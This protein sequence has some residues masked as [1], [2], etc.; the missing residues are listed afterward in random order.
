MNH[1][2]IDLRS[3]TVTR[4]S[5]G[6]RDAMMRADV[7]DDVYGEDPTVNFLQE[8]VSE[9]L[10]KDDALY[11]PSGTMSNQIAIKI[12]TQPG[13]EVICEENCHIFN[14]EAGASAFLSRVQMHTLRGNYGVLNIDDVKN[15]IR[16]ENVH[17]PPTGL[18]CIENTHNRAGGTIYPL[19]NIAEIAKLAAQ[20]GIPLHLDGARLMN[21]VVATGIP[22]REWTGYFDSVSLCFSKGLGAPIGSVLSGTKEFIHKARKYRKIFGGGMRQVG[23][24]AAACLYAL[25]NNIKRL[26]DD[27]ENACLLAENLKNLPGLFIDMKQVQTNMVM[28]HVRHSKFNSVTLSQALLQQGV[29]ANAVDAERIRAVTHLDITKDQILSAVEIF[30]D[31]IKDA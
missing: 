3:D 7:G 6:M 25:D 31:L 19:E 14:Y 27:H 9:L 11:V 28:I 13:Q 4:P 10:G 24:L 16:A 15:A 2:R 23:I 17:L 12:H 20:K 29:A 1:I 26:A 18:I 8:R 30:R 21:A 22:A 5:R